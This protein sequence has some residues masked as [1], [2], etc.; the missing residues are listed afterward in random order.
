MVSHLKKAQIRLSNAESALHQLRTEHG[1]TVE[2]LS[3]QWDQQRATQMDVISRTAR[4]KKER[5]I[6]LL[7]MEEKL[8]EAREDLRKL[9]LK[10]KRA[11]TGREK[12]ELLNI[13]QSLVLMETQIHNAAAELG[14][15]EFLEL[16]GLTGNTAI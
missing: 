14:T 13:P 7:N 3:V 8:I 9:K 15:Q 5:M 1:H 6:D 11:R 16:T 12:Q 10:K 4:E 2:Y